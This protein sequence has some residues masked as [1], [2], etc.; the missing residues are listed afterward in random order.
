MSAISRRACEAKLINRV[1]IAVVSAMLVGVGVIC[2]YGLNKPVNTLSIKGELSSLERE[3]LTQLL[4]EQRVDGV[5]DVDLQDI[6]ESLRSLGWAHR[7]AVR[8]DWPNRLV[9]SVSKVQPVARRLDGTYLSADGEDLQLPDVYEQLPQF[10]L[11]ISTAAQAMDVFRLLDQIASREGLAI[12]E[13]SEDGQG[14]WEARLDTGV[15][16][17]LGSEQLS[18]RM[19]RLLFAYRRV[20]RDEERAVDY[21]DARYHSG[22]AVRYSDTPPAN[23]SASVMRN[24]HHRMDTD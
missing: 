22:V 20:L 9:V 10:D 17:L 6:Q 7:V 5:L 18:E 1:M 2:W 13:L 23:L 19:H 21:I 3:T 14:E 15:T 24:T 8:R 4:S 16:I 12:R 11:S